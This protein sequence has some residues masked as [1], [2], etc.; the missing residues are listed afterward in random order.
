M[1]CLTPIKGWRSY[2]QN[3][4]GKRSIVFQHVN[5][6]KSQPV[7]VPCGR[8]IGC[9]LEKSRQWALRAEKEASLYE[10]NCVVTLTYAKEHLPLN[11]SIDV[12]D[13][14][15]F[16][17]R[18]REHFTGTTIRSFGC[19]EYGEK[20]GRPHYH[21]I[22]FNLDFSDKVQDTSM[23]SLE[24]QHKYFTSAILDS[25]WGMGK[26]QIMDCNFETAAYVARYVTKKFNN[27]DPQKIADH[28]GE[29]LPERSVCVSRRPGIGKAWYDLNKQHLYKAD[30]LY[31]RG[32]AMQPPQYFNRRYEIDNPEHYAKIKQYR[33]AKQNI[34]N[35]KIKN[36]I[37]NRNYTNAARVGHRSR[38][39]A[40]ITC[41]E[42]QFI[43]LKRTLE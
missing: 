37:L 26:T 6:I 3:P 19:A 1:A 23:V 40:E 34:S 32:V 36:Q 13:P 18:L 35:D 27:K 31:S 8:C 4:T 24:P 38:T 12:V 15:N 25:L 10:Q 7:T 5:G 17:K 9:R 42:A 22:L 14:V 16:M 41:K 11:G 29:K 2:V 30:L 28:Y 21:I 43:Q 20:H 33:K 39:R